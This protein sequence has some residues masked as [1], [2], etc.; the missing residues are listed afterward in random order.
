LTWNGN[1]ERDLLGYR[2]YRAQVKGEEAIPLFDIA[3]QDTIY[4][5]T[6]NILNLNRNIYYTVS[7][8]DLRYNQSDLAPLLELEKPDVI[9]PSSPVISGYK[10]KKDGI[11]IQWINSPDEG[12]VQHRVRR[13]VK[14]KGYEPVNL[15][16]TIT[17]NA[18]K[19][20]VDTSAMTGVHYIYTV[21]AMKKNWLESP[22]S[23]GLTAFTNHPKQQTMDLERFNAVVDK[24]NK[25]LKL[26]WS[27]KLQNV[28]TTNSTKAQTMKIYPCGKRY[29]EISTKLLTT[30]LC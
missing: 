29:R 1:T 4:K 12:V 10:I 8:L 25:M 7:S 17:D 2:V 19:S 6:I 27:D 13:R 16:K 21:T 5:D 26:T 23:N 22:P 9:P 15:L 11:E 18:V 24:Q 14:G 28:T 30:I 3:L 20:Y